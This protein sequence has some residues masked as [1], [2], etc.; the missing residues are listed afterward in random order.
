M[1]KTVIGPRDVPTYEST[2]SDHRQFQLLCEENVT[3]ATDLAAGI[4]VLPP[5]QCQPGAASH[6]KTEELYFV[7]KGKGK[8]QVGEEVHDIEEGVLVYIPFNT[9]HRLYNTQ[10]DEELR[11]FWA[12]T[13]RLGRFEQYKPMRDPGWKIVGP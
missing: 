4:V 5:G 3:G 1:R 8:I 11:V 2:S 7:L 9:G 12:N 10:E 13:P 6:P